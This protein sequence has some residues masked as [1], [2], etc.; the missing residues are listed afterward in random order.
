[1][2]SFQFQCFSVSRR[3]LA[4][5]V[6]E[7]VGLVSSSC[8]SFL[9]LS[10]DSAV[11]GCLVGMPIEKH[12]VGTMV[13]ETLGT[14]SELTVCFLMILWS[15]ICWRHP[16]V[17]ESKYLGAGSECWLLVGEMELPQPSFPLSSSVE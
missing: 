11:E 13:V 16:F 5:E 6:A 1:M 14:E 3:E 12:W 10:F 2:P 4:E 17:T 8:C 7:L 15:G 9:E